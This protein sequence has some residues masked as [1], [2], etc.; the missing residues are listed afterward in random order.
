MTRKSTSSMAPMDG[1]RPSKEMGTNMVLT[2]ATGISA[3]RN[4][5]AG[6]VFKILF[7]FMLVVPSILQDDLT[8]VRD[9]SNRFEDGKTSC[10]LHST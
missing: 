2:T 10:E 8:S 3:N 7:R 1:D 6:V 5:L 4:L 9:W